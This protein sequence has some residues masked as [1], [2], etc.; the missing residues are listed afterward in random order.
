V[1][2]SR[3][4]TWRPCTTRAGGRSRRTRA[5]EGPTLLEVRTLRLWGHFEGDA[6]GYR[7]DL[8]EATSRDPIPRYE[9]ALRKAGHLDDA[10]IERIRRTAHDR[11]EDA[12]AFAKGSPEPDPASATSYAFA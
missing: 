6:Q 12:I 3:A 5:G 4:T 9:Q 11:V 1:N 10:A 8:E 2:A 7:P